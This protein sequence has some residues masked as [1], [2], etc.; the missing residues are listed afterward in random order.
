MR[1]EKGI[2]SRL[3][4]FGLLIILVGGFLFLDF[5]RSNRGESSLIPWPSLIN[6]GAASRKIYFSTAGVL[7]EMGISNKDLILQYPEE[8]KKGKQEWV[9]FT[10]QIRVPANRPLQKYY[11]DIEKAVKKVGGRIIS[12]RTFEAKGSRSLMMVIGFRSI[13]T[14]SLTLEQPKK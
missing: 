7:S 3:V 11:Q 4:I 8:K 10:A 9:H 1:N 6:Y 12:S 13:V 14:Y 2:S 5:L